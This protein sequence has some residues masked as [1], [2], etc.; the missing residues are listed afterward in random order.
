MPRKDIFHETVITSLEKEGWQ[1]IDDPLR[2]VAGGVGLFIDLTAEP[3]ITFR[4]D[5]ERVAIEIKS[6]QIQSQITTFYEALGKYLTYRKA[7]SMNNL[8]LNLYLA[9]PKESFD[10]IFQK[11][12]VKELVKEY[13][14]NLL[15]YNTKNQ[16]IESWIIQ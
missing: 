7:L 3:I 15:V 4:R 16:T 14:V 1:I 13:R 11:E 8:G 9:V 5:N 2:I 10:T 12:L 6:F